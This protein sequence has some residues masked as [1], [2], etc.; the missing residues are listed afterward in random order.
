MPRRLAQAVQESVTS[1]GYLPTLK[2]QN[3]FVPA[4]DIPA[5]KAEPIYK[6]LLVPPDIP[7]VTP[8]GHAWSRASSLA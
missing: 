6:S 2:A 4:P 8:T 1:S 3:S 7:A 5:T